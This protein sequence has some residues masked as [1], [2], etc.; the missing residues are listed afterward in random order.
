MTWLKV[1]GAAIGIFIA[2]AVVSSVVHFL[3]WAAFAA[4]VVGVIVLAVKAVT[5][6]RGRVSAPKAGREVSE[7]SYVSEPPYASPASR[8]QP[9]PRP[10][11]A[12]VDDELAK[13]KREMGH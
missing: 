10:Q 6:A 8:P 9:A 11:P 2:L 4:L 1:A 12:N 5:R 13:L 3:I 7:A